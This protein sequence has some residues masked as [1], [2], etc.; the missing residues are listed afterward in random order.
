VDPVEYNICNQD[1]NYVYTG[2]LV[3]EKQLR[4]DK[5]LCN[6]AV[7]CFEYRFVN[8]DMEIHVMDNHNEHGP[9]RCVK[10]A[11]FYKFAQLHVQPV[12]PARVASQEE[13]VRLTG[14]IPAQRLHDLQVA[15]SNS[16]LSKRF[17]RISTGGIAFSNSRPL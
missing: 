2:A 3:S 1:S 16:S 17:M 6:H 4:G 10:F 7:V 12:D 13:G 15:C 5:S 8:G 11:A 14:A 9:P